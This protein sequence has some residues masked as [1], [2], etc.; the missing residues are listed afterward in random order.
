[1]TNQKLKKMWGDKYF[2]FVKPFDEFAYFKRENIQVYLDSKE[3]LNTNYESNW[4]YYY[5]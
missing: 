5:K 1:M 3:N 2:D 4:Y